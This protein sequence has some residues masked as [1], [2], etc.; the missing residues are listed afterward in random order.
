MKISIGA[1]PYIQPNPVL[2]IGSYDENGTPNL[3]TVAWGGVCCSVPPCVAI[4]P[5]KRTKTWGNIMAQQAFTV[6]IPSES[7]VR[8]TDYVGIYK[9]KQENKFEALGLTPVRSQTVNAPY[10][11]EF[12]FIL[13]CKVIDSLEIGE[14][15]QQFIGEVMDIKVDEAVL[16]DDGLPDIQ[17]VSP[18]VYDEVS[19]NYFSVGGLLA[20]A[21]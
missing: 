19:R 18:F 1:K 6:N 16:G 10:A 2:V 14:Y 8:E 4:S 12:P 15:T 3:M 17:K 21:F 5:A 20:K 11:E 13:E 7:L 9:G